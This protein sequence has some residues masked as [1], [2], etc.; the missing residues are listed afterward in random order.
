[1]Q[2]GHVLESASNYANFYMGITLFNLPMI[3]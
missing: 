3:V 1:M 2:V